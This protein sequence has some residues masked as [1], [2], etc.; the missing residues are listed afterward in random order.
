[1][2]EFHGLS[3]DKEDGTRSFAGI[4][5]EEI[6][7]DVIIVHSLTFLGFLTRQPKGCFARIARA[8][9]GCSL[10]LVEFYMPVLGN[11]VFCHARILHL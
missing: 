5:F 6:G 1:M 4:A 2:A 9:R 11:P 3:I 8:H 10:V 7:G